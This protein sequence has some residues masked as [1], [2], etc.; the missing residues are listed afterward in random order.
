MEPR[1][2]SDLWRAHRAGELDASSYSR[3]FE[4]RVRALSRVDAVR[5]VKELLAAVRRKTP[6]PPRAPSPERG[7]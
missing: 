5:E 4:V 2:L 3:A 1:T 7:R 6:S